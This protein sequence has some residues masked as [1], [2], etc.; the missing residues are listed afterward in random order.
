MNSGNMLL[1][2][3]QELNE[4]IKKLQAVLNKI[5][6]NTKPSGTTP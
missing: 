2:Q 4:N 6:T 5:E 1:D 3:L